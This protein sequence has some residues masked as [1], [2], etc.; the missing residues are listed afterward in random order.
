MLRC[1]T[2]SSQ[3]FQML[4][5]SS[6]LFN[7][8]TIDQISYNWSIF[9]FIWVRPSINVFFSCD[10]NSFELKINFSLFFISQHRFPIHY[11]PNYSPDW[12]PRRWDAALLTTNNKPHLHLVL[13]VKQNS[14]SLMTLSL[15]LL[16]YFWQWI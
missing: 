5:S 12:L 4:V 8:K 14:E 7:V 10:F 1:S 16:L 13:K 15:H 11:H 6:L 2:N 9:I 3:D